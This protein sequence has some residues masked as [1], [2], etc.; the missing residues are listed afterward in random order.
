VLA[1]HEAA[2]RRLYHAVP[3]LEAH[4]HA[5]V[6]RFAAGTVVDAE[7]LEGISRELMS[8]VDPDDPA[9]LEAAMQRASGFRLDPTPE[10]QRILERLQGVVCLVG[11]WAR[12]EV[13]RAAEGRVPSLPRIAEVQRRR[14]AE[15]GDGDD[16]LAGLLGLDLQPDDEALGE[17]FVAEVEEAL[18][19]EGLRRALEHPENLPDA[20]ELADPPA[21]L[22]RMAAGGDVPDDPAAL[23]AELGEAPREGSAAERVAERDDEDED[24]GG[25]G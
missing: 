20:T 3:W 23:F 11:A 1:L 22:A 9:S 12:H 6:A 21:W 13:A 24:G 25:A 17:R 5:L 16:L 2:L 10:Q 18:G 8:G 19:P 7:R 15:R 4:V 14:R